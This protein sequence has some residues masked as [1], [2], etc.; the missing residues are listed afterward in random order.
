MFLYKYNKM[1]TMLEVYKLMHLILL[2]IKI[3]L[4]LNK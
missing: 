1:K 2:V 4:N 3:N